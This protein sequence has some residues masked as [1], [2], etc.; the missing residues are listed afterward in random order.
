[1]GVVE[2]FR[3]LAVER[4]E[5]HFSDQMAFEETPTVP[6]GVAIAVLGMESVAI[7]IW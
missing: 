5:L 6:K 2:K 7:G 4:S 1:M 3:P